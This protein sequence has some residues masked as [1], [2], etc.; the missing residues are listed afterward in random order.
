MYVK[1]SVSGNDVISTS[2]SQLLEQPT[3]HKFAVK[4]NSRRG[5]GIVD[6]FA[7]IIRFISFCM[8]TTINYNP[9]SIWKVHWFVLLKLV[10][11]SASRKL[12]LKVL[13]FGSTT[14]DSV[15]LKFC[16]FGNAYFFFHLT[17]R[18]SLKIT[19]H[20]VAPTKHR[21]QS[22]SRKLAWR[23]CRVYWH[24]YEHQKSINATYLT[25]NV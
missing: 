24:V 4:T 17:A 7:H 11:V 3:T 19:T 2:T 5:N 18:V 20:T 14:N 1:R 15:R 8:L 25:N 13:S 6:Y 21:E 22:S 10:T 16:I 12:I 23:A 9:K